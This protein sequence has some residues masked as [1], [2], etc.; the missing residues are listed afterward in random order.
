MTTK[1]RS[2]SGGPFYCSKEAPMKIIAAVLLL[3]AAP[4]AAQT[5]TPSQIKPGTNGQS[6]QT[7]GGKAAWGNSSTSVPSVFGRTG[8]ILPVAGDYNCSQITSA[9]CSLPP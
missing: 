5:I 8:A 7:V 6:L 2:P 9:I 1:H 3:L 4:L